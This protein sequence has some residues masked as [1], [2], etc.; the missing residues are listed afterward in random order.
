MAGKAL[1]DGDHGASARCAAGM[2]ETASAFPVDEL[3][4]D[5]EEAGSERRCIVTGQR[6]AR[7]TMIRFVRGPD[8]AVV[9]D[10]EERLPGRGVW[11]VADPGAIARAV[12]EG[13]FA[14]GFK[15]QALA[16]PDLPD[17]VARR[18][19]RRCIDLVSLARRS[20]VALAGSER[21][22]EQVERARSRRPGAW[23][24][25]L[26]LAAAEAAE[27]GRRKLA[28]LAPELPQLDVLASAELGEAFG[29]DQV[30]HA[31]VGPG[32]LAQRLIRDLARLGNFRPSTAGGESARRSAATLPIAQAA[33]GET[34]LGS[35]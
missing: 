12:K 22:R 1:S 3:A 32:G 33:G 5:A 2:L 17:A 35:L 31:A 11:V 34:R 20:G 15:G 18:L 13:R 24:P 7:E 23:M 14:R 4:E 8:S 30:A 6:M 28:A 10:L 21:I 25:V 16:Q 9:A 29:R 27:D 26:L 19:S